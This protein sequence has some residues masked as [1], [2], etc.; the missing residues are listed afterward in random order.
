MVLQGT[1]NILLAV[2][3][4]ALGTGSLMLVRL[5]PS[6]GKVVLC[7]CMNATSACTVY[8]ISLALKLTSLL[9]QI[10]RRLSGFLH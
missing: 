1:E 3:I 7:S 6:V 2:T 4:Y 10:A 9:M 8:N 5:K